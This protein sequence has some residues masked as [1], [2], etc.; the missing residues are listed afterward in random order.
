MKITKTLL[1]EI[2]KGVLKETSS[3]GGGS[4]FTPG[5]GEQYTG[6]KAFTYKDKN[7]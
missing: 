2:I 6:K 5:Q 4:S 7:K 3:T 1:K